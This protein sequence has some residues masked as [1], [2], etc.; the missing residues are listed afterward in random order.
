MSESVQR[1]P[2]RLVDHCNLYA[3]YLY[4]VDGKILINS[5]N[6][7]LNVHNERLE[8]ALKSKEIRFYRN[9]TMANVCYRYF[10]TSDEQRERFHEDR[11]YGSDEGPNKAYHVYVDEDVDRNNSEYKRLFKPSFEKSH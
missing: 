7:F 11:I 1:W 8:D 3:K 6:K 5:D 10:I 4:D 9:S 2:V